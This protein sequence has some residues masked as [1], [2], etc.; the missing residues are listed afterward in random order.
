VLGLEIYS[1]VKRA[2]A[3]GASPGPAREGGAVASAAYSVCNMFLCYSGSLLTK[4]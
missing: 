4:V 1:T 2:G 3:G